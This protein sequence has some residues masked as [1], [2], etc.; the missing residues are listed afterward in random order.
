MQREVNPANI[1]I[2]VLTELFNT[3]GTEVT[4]WSD[5]VGED[6]QVQCSHRLFPF[7]YTDHEPMQSGVCIQHLSNVRR[8]PGQY[9]VVTTSATKASLPPEAKPCR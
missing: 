1:D 2:V 3:P 6:F 5:E 8:T 4:P 7:G 9:T